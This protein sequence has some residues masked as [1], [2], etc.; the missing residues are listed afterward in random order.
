[1][2][3]VLRRAAPGTGFILGTGDATAR[4][5]PVGNLRAVTETV[6]SCGRYPLEDRG[7]P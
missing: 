4:G 5:T 7:A 2:R 3:D 6:W 1:V